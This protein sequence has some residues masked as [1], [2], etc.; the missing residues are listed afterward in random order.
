MGVTKEL[1]LSYS[2]FT[3]PIHYNYK[4]MKTGTQTLIN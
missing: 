4:M 1:L 2:G 3:N